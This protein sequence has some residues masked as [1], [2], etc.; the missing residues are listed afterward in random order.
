MAARATTAWK[1]PESIRAFAPEATSNAPGTRAT[2]TSPAR[3]PRRRRV[4]MAAASMAS[5]TVG[6]HRAHTTPM[7]NPSASRLPS[8]CLGEKDAAARRGTRMLKE[9]PSLEEEEL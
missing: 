6:F 8:Y 2:E 5:V 1:R 9:L 4:S 3:A 7:R